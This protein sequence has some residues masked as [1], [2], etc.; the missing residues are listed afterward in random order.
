M[1][2]DKN[3]DKNGVLSKLLS[4]SDST[5]KLVTLAL[6]VVTGG[7]N[8]LVTK[9]TGRTTDRE[10]EQ[11]IRE[12]HD[13]HAVLDEAMNRQKEIAKSIEEMRKNGNR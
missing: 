6:V 2:T 3:G 5:I 9:E 8:L 13:V 12:I 4:D 7:G 1:G 11:A 10:I